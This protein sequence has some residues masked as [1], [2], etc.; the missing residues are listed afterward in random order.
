METVGGEGAEEGHRRR[1][2]PGTRRGP[3]P[4]LGPGPLP[5]QLNSC[6]APWTIKAQ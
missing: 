6:T 4:A 1:V 5:L 2:T 3:A